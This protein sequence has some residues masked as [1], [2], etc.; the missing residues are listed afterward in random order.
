MFISP[1]VPDGTNDEGRE[2]CTPVGAGVGARGNLVGLKVGGK[3]GE[4]DSLALVGELVFGRAVGRRVGEGVLAITFCY[5]YWIEI[6]MG[7]ECNRP[8]K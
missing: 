3:F 6:C 7:R 1:Y 8:P 4:V 5:D 2:V